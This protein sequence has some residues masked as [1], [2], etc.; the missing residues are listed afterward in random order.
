MIDMLEPLVIVQ[1]GLH[2][3]KEDCNLAFYLHLSL[4]RSETVVIGLCEHV[5][6]G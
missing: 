4:E 3:E 5:S 1:R 6:I 2:F